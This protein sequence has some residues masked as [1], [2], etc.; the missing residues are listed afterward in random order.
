MSTPSH[1]VTFCQKKICEGK[2]CKYFD[3]NCNHKMFRPDK[4]EPKTRTCPECGHVNPR[5]AMDCEAC[6][7][8]IQW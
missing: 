4:P 2:S 6:G 8:P 7:T 1:E 5:E 3:N